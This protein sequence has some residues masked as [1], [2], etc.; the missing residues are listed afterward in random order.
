MPPTTLT[1]QQPVSQEPP[2]QSKCVAGASKTNKM[3]YSILPDTQNGSQKPPRQPKCLPG[4]HQ[5]GKMSLR[6]IPDSQ[7]VYQE[8]PGHAKCGQ[9]VSQTA[10]L[11]TPALQNHLRELILENIC[12]GTW[13]FGIVL[14]VWAPSRELILEEICLGTWPFGKGFDILRIVL[15]S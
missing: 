7:N 8:L 4:A 5:S 3:C 12:L 10:I 6:S 1:E 14:T 15:G 13:P 11:A 9:G 2:R